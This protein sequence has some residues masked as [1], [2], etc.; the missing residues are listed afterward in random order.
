MV[1]RTLMF[2]TLLFILF[3]TGC[4]DKT[5][6][7]ENGELTFPKN[8][9]INQI[10]VLGTHNSYSL[11]ADQRVLEYLEPNY[12]QMSSG[13]FKNLS[14]E[15]KKIITPDMVQGTY[16]TLKEAVLANNWPRLS[17]SLGKF[18]FLSLSSTVRTRADIDTYKAKIN[19]KTRA[20]AAFNNGA[21]IVSTDYF[22]PGNSYGT[23]HFVELPSKK[24][25]KI[26]PLF[27]TNNHK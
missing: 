8:I 27:S 15:E 13:Y 25:V 24:P 19:D 10:Q 20:E 12:E 14:E 26:N 1:F 2:S 18:V 16:P 7:A 21:Q 9:R 3:I 22:K 11:P 6:F 17:E 4:S 23:E 5:F